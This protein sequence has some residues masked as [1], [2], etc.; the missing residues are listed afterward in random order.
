VVRTAAAVAVLQ[1]ALFVALGLP[2]GALGV[3]WP[4]MRTAVGRPLGELG[5]ILA[6]GTIGYLAGSPSVASL[7]RRFGT[8]RTMTA[9]AGIAAVALTA[10]ALTRS[11]AL[12]LAAAFVL[13]TSRGMVDAGLNA[14]VALHGGVRRLGVLHGAYGIGTS[15]G[16][17]LVVASLATGTWRAAWLVMAALDAVL[18]VA[19]WRLHDRWPPEL[20]EPAGGPDAGAAD[21]AAVHVG[22][23]VAVT[24]LCFA[25]LVGAEYSTG[26]WS[27]TLL[28]DGRGMADAA[29][30]IWVASYWV[31]LTVARFALGVFG[32]RVDRV[33]L[34]DGSCAVELAGIGVLW[35]D[36]AG[37][38]AAG[39]PVAGVGFAN[40]FP[41]LVAL[42]PDRLGPRRSSRVIGWSVAAASLGGTAVAAGAGIL[43]DR[44]GPTVLAPTLMAAAVVFTAFHL[45]LVRLAPVRPDRRLVA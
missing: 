3:A 24:M 36:P 19:G 28:T 5:V 27:Y 6:L 17:L 15:L 38:G 9:A 18:T 29:A 14:Y 35:W 13:G 45:A 2:D 30:G 23:T 16:S 12:L 20:I 21:R 11:W 26:A 10:W 22:V 39:L 1:V 42:M 33:R 43:V 44:Y 25:A 40:L 41:T 31:G 34:L 7:A 37:L 4:S 32:D 8:P